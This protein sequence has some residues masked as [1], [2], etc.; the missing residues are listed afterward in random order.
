MKGVMINMLDLIKK[1]LI[2]SK[3]FIFIILPF[4][5][6]YAAV[7][8]RFDNVYLLVNMMFTMF[9]SAGITIIEDRYPADLFLLSL[10]V[11]RKTLVKARY[12]SSLITAGIGMILYLGYGFILDR[13]F[14]DK[15]TMFVELLTPESIVV[16]ATVL[17]IMLAVFYPYY[18]KW[19]LWKG[20][21][22]LSV[23][24]MLVY[25]ACSSFLFAASGFVGAS[26]WGEFFRSPGKA[27]IRGVILVEQAVGRSVMLSLVL[28]LAGCVVYLSMMLSVR[29][30]RKRE[31]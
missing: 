2:I 12:L 15:T 22:V 8:F 7:M 13:L 18:Y 24:F 28:F 19:G 11:D 31:F 1:D 6:L 5:F 14:K 4:Y 26:G 3:N 10:P 17:L 27:L 29:V 20:M 25:M 21:V 9:L 16:F 23:T 30:Y